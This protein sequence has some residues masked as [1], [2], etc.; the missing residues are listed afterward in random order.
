MFHH[1]PD[2]DIGGHCLV[3][4]TDFTYQNE[5]GPASTRHP[6]FSFLISTARKGHKQ[7]QDSKYISKSLPPLEFN[8]SRA[9][10]QQEVKT[11]DAESLENLPEGFNNKKYQWIDLDGDGICGI[12]SEQADGWYYKPNLSPANIVERGESESVQPLFGPVRKVL[13]R[14]LLTPASSAFSFM[15]IDGDSQLELAAFSGSAPGFYEH[16]K[17][18]WSPH[19]AFRSLPNISWDNPNLR[20]IDLNGNGLSDVLIT[21]SNHLILYASVTEKSAIGPIWGMV[22]SAAK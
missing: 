7:N 5:L 14:P 15:D 13:E 22:V 17:E 3:Q 9:T 2:E 1:F 21:E 6:V 10:I 12:F 4:S 19:K 18:S 16:G 20:F 8:Y 11:M